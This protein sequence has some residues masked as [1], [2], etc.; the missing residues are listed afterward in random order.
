MSLFK[1]KRQRVFL[2]SYQNEMIV[3]EQGFLGKK[4]NELGQEI[5]KTLLGIR[6]YNN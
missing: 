3:S 5:S 2:S 6:S 4:N 1:K